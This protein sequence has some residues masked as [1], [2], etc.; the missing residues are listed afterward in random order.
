MTTTTTTTRMSWVIFGT[1]NLYLY[2]LYSLYLYRL[3]SLYLYRLYAN[4]ARTRLPVPEFN[5]PAQC[6]VTF[7]RLCCTLTTQPVWHMS[8]CRDEWLAMMKVRQSTFTFTRTGEHTLRPEAQELN[9]K[10]SRTCRVVWCADLTQHS[11]RLNRQRCVHRTTCF[12]Y[13]VI[14]AL[15]DL[16]KSYEL[17]AELSIC[18]RI[19]V[20]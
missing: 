18:S 4:L 20:L 2:R 10:M 19:L 3:Y 14:R 9:R 12:S 15:N 11:H 7:Q 8:E 5:A 6:S 13:V 17:T 16:S 1:N